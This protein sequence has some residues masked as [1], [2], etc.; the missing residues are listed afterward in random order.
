LKKLKL[1][2]HYT[3]ISLIVPQ[4]ASAANAPE[5]KRVNKQELKHE[6]V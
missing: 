3:G 6:D 4:E 1:K 2:N 5:R